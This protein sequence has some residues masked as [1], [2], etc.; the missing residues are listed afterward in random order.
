M[1]DIP[2]KLYLSIWLDSTIIYNEGTLLNLDQKKYK[3]I[4][5]KTSN[6]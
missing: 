6:L 4:L 1:L 5:K 2:Y 3:N